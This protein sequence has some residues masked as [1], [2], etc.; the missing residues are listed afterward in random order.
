[1]KERTWDGVYKQRPPQSS[2]IAPHP[3][4]SHLPDPN[5]EQ[6]QDSVRYWIKF[7]DFYQMPHITYYNS[8]DHLVQILEKATPANLRKTSG[9]MREYNARVKVALVTQWKD[10]LHRIAKYSPN[11]P[12]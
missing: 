3:S 10:I 4:Q 6:N 5:D 7:S 8:V 9:L 2:S 11:N 1:M 12:H